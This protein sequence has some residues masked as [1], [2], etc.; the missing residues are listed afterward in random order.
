MALIDLQ[1]NIY[2]ITK[3]PD[4]VSETLVAIKQATLRAH[5]SDFYKKDLYE[6]TITPLT[7][8]SSTDNRYVIDTSVSPFVRFRKL[9]YAR[10]TPNSNP[11]SYSWDN[12]NS[13]PWQVLQYQLI[14]VDSIFDNYDRMLSNTVYEAG[15]SINIRTSHVATSVDIGY[16]RLP[17]ISTG[18]YS[19]WIADLY[20]FVIENE[21]AASVFKMIGKDAESTLYRNMWAESVH[22]LQMSMIP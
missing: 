9:M 11:S 16:Y 18:T 21:A 22:L 4:L 7:S 17:D 10:E 3:R 19:S 15:N 6:L 13:T 8:V 20:P 12:Q 5:L 14:E 1:T 2:D